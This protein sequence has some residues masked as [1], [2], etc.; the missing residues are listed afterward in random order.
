ME[1]V[2]IHPS[3]LKKLLDKLEE[4]RIELDNLNSY[5]RFNEVK[6]DGIE[7]D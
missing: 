5:F 6:S 1:V 7:E 2:G 4:I 3:D